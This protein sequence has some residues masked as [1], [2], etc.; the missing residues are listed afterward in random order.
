MGPATAAWPH[1]ETD[2]HRRA[3]LD[4]ADRLLAGTPVHS[5]GRLSIVQLA[6]EAEV[7]YWVVAQKHTDLRDHFQKLAAEPR[8]VTTEPDPVDGYAQLRK[9]HNELRDHCQGLEQLLVL[10]ATAIS[11]LT[12]ENEALRQQAA[13]RGTTVTPLARRR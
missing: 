5:T 7:K 12:L 6:I 9:D 8:H 4:A 3:L 10:Y 2:P 13:E 11:E 1:A